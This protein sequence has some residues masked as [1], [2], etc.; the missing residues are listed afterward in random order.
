MM[1]EQTI[2]PESAHMEQLERSRRYEP[3]RGSVTIRFRRI[4]LA[5]YWV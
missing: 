1:N 3:R 5:H 2:N 4:E